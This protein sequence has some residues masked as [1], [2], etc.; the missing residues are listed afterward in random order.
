MTKAKSA[1]G[2]V[3]FVPQQRFDTVQYVEQDAPDD[4]VPFEVTIRANLTFGELNALVWAKDTPMTEMHAMFAPFVAGWNLSGINEDDEVVDIP[5][6]ADGG[7][8][9]FEHLP[10]ALFWEIVRDIKLRSNRPV[11]PKRNGRSAG[12]PAPSNSNGTGDG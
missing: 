5:A 4:A 1:S 12:T 9:Q 6:P 7:P 10:N 11:D 2:A 8:E 3:R